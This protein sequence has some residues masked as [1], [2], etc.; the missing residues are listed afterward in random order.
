MTSVDPT[1]SDDRVRRLRLS[2]RPLVSSRS[3]S[4][5]VEDI[6]DLVPVNDRPEA[7][8]VFLL[9]PNTIPCAHPC[10]LVNGHAQEWE[11]RRAESLRVGLAYVE[12]AEV[13]S[14]WLGIRLRHAPRGRVWVE[15]WQ[16]TE[17]GSG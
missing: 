15:W 17:R 11:E 6:V 9:A 16:S 7:L 5:A 13:H 8:H 4:H 10:T 1:L 12:L 2:G 14:P 3:N